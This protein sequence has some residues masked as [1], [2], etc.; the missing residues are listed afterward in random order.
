MMSH[1]CQNFLEPRGK[2]TLQ[3]VD[4]AVNSQQEAKPRFSALG[5]RTLTG[6]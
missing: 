2:L 5:S 1:S 6:F 4:L 3:G